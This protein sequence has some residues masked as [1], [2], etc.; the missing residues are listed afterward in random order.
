MVTV[1]GEGV[2][3]GVTVGIAGYA[4]SLVILEL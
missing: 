4:N 3:V 2:G 1:L